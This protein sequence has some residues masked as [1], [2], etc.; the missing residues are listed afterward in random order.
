MTLKKKGKNENKKQQQMI[1][2][3]IILA[4]IVVFGVVL[5]FARPNINRFDYTGIHAERTDDGAFILGDPAAPITVVAWEDFLCPHCQ[6]YQ[7]TIKKFFE[8]YVRTG[9]ARFEFRMLPIS[10]GQSA[11]TFGLVECVAII[12][13]DPF[14]F[15]PAHDAMFALTTTNGTNYDGGDFA[16]EVGIPYGELLDCVEDADQVDTDLALARSVDD[17]STISGTPALA[18]RLND[19]PIRTDIIN[20]QPTHEQLASL[21]AFAESLPQ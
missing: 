14:A 4:A 18:W 1:I 21:V 19:G 12:E 20:R 3:G 11:F 17:G 2:A 15:W 16:D 6:N 10:Q 8:D 13:D 5:W 7:S 9:R